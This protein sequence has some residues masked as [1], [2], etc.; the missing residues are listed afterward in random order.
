MNSSIQPNPGE[1]P[2]TD[3]QTKIMM[4]AIADILTT[5]Q[6]LT[7][8]YERF[9]RLANAGG[10]MNKSTVDYAKGET[11]MTD[12]QFKQYETFREKCEAL[13]K[14]NAQLRAGLSRQCPEV[15]PKGETPMTDF[16]FKQIIAMVY[17]I[18]KASFESGKSHEEILAVIASLRKY[19]DID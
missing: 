8:A 16:Q 14:E 7:E 4:A 5:S 17:E 3:L 10:T 11:P 15:N 1:T 19:T 12:Y 9:E 6:S 13:E 18:L 2:M